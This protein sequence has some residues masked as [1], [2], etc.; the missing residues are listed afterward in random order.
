MAWIK[1]FETLP[2]HKKTHDLAILMGWQRRYAVGFLIELW[3]WAIN[4]ADDGDFSKITKNAFSSYFDFSQ[5]DAEKCISALKSVGF[6]TADMK[7]NNWHD[8]VARF[9]EGRRKSVASNLQPTCNQNASNLQPSIY[10]SKSKSK[11]KSKNESKEKEEE[12]LTTLVPAIAET[13]PPKKDFDIENGEP[14][15]TGALPVKS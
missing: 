4:H 5:D 8:Y 15:H 10:K 13:L 6:F 2:Q 11:S 3:L 12:C 1:V 14:L 9:L 7:I